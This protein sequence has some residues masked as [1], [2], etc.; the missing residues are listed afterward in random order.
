M[1]SD[2]SCK[3]N[4]TAFDVMCWYQLFVK[5]ISQTSS[6]WTSCKAGIIWDCYKSKIDFPT[7]L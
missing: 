6:V 5:L 4:E 3:V 1:L 2:K 7:D